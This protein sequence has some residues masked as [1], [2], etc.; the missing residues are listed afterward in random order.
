MPV[1][2]DAAVIGNR[3]LSADYN[4]LALDAPGIAARA[5]PGQFVMIKPSRGLDPLLR[6]PFS[7]FEVLRDQAGAPRGVSL[8]N[9]RIGVGTALLYDAEPGA[10][11]PCLGPL[12]R[13]FEPI[14]PPA[15]AWM[16][17]GGV[18]LGP[19]LTLAE[20]LAQRGTAT[21]LFYGARTG[22]DLYCVDR[23]ERLGV[24]I[25]LATEDGSR[26]AAG[27]I[28]VPLEFAL[29]RQPPSRDTKVFVCGPTPMMRACAALASTHRRACDVSLEQ[30][31][32]CGLGG[33]YSC[34]VMARDA[35]G[36]PHHTR[37]CIEGP[38]FDAARVVW[39]AVGSH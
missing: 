10:R 12:G 11:L 14:D 2:I 4:V 6:R 30:V 29:R 20:A 23:F 15:D 33:C 13:P 21:T 3:R 35:H 27:R 24:T 32:G 26:G 25:V 7:I 18:G 9:K 5:R 17:A 16:V 38:V 39:D 22:A 36:T 28:T 19:F 1:D 34:V 37:T 31:M 8:L